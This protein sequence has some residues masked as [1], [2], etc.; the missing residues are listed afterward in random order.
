[1][2]RTRPPEARE[3]NEHDELTITPNLASNKTHDIVE[4]ELIALPEWNEASH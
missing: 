2:S 4:D 1:M 3:K